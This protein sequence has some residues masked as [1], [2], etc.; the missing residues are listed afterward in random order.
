MQHKALYFIFI[1]LSLGF[2]N[3]SLLKILLCTL[4]VLLCISAA[5]APNIFIKNVA[6]CCIIRLSVI[7]MNTFA[8][9]HSFLPF[10][11]FFFFICANFFNSCWSWSSGFFFYFNFFEA[12]M[13][14]QLFQFLCMLLVGGH[15]FSKSYVVLVNWLIFFNPLSVIFHTLFFYIGNLVRQTSVLNLNIVALWLLNTFFMFWCCFVRGVVYIFFTNLY[16]KIILAKI[17]HNKTSF[18]TDFPCNYVVNL[19]PQAFTYVHF[20]C[21]Y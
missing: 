20:I 16:G 21:Y 19:S 18:I 6:V 3:L 14:D 15:V 4:K 9:L 8:W 12:F 5:V 11:F 2:Q 1:K 13:Y 10:L 7:F 17:W